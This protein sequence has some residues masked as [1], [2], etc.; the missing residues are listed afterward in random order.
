MWKIIFEKLN[1]QKGSTTQSVFWWKK[2]TIWRI[3]NKKLKSCEFLKKNSKKHK[4]KKL[5]IAQI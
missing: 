2:T 4:Q 5:K 1:K 3:F